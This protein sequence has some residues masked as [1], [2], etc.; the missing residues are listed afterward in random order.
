MTDSSEKCIHCDKAI[1]HSGGIIWHAVG[2]RIFPQYC[3][4]IATEDDPGDIRK[5]DL[6]SSS[7]LHEPRIAQ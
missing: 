4:A 7:Q 3:Q 6:Y 5:G 2:E 1:S